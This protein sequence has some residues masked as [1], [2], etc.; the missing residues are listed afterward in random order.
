M[1]TLYIE[2]GMGIAGDM[3]AASL[4]ELVDSEAMLAKINKVFADIA[5][6]SVASVKKCGIVGTHFEVKI[7]EHKEVEGHHHEHS[8][9]QSIN[10]KISDLS[11][12]AKVKKDAEAIYLAIAE[13]ESAVHNESVDKIHFHEVGDIDAMVDIVSTAML[14]AELGA[15]KIVAS[16]IALGSGYIKCQHG[17]LPVPAPAT[18]L[19]LAGIPTY[20]DGIKG[21][22]CT[23]TGA[24]LIKYYATSYGEKPTMV[25]DKI[26]YGM[27]TKDF[28]RANCVRVYLGE[29]EGYSQEKY[30]SGSVTEI[31]F[32]VD[33]MT[34][35]DMAY[36]TK[37]LLK[38]GAREVFSTAVMGKKSRMGQLITVICNCSEEDK[39]IDLIFK[40]TTTIGVRYSTLKRKMLERNITTVKSE[41]VRL[42]VS[43]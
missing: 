5:E 39:Y 42:G 17:I 29:T 27:G 18:S 14:M 6:V 20:N 32:N 41:L 13:A 31:T 2:C 23:P 11:I 38:A 26:G 21:E 12:S 33:D 4:L 7:G 16:P 28:E 37:V 22:L 1:K 34:G 25:V 9:L 15:E 10:K 43:I 36:A 24:A 19:L 40:H 3:L 30:I 8:T 35:E